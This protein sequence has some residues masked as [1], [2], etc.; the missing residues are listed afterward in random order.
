MHNM[1]ECS[2]S[3]GSSNSSD[4]SSTEPVDVESVW[5]KL[6]PSKEW[7]ELMKDPV[8]WRYE[9]AITDKDEFNQSRPCRIEIHTKYEN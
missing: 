8:Q 1:G 4:W 9:N 7:S 2:T 5:R 3:A 6:K